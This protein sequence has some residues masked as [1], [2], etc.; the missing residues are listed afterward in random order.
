MTKRKEGRVM[1]V[2]F[3]DA[4]VLRMDRR[5]KK[6]KDERCWTSWTNGE[7]GLDL[8]GNKCINYEWDLLQCGIRVPL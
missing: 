1:G 3:H 5:Y 7:S 6:Y 2:S 8:H 4:S